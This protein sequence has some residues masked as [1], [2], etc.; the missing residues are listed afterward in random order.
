MKLRKSSHK[1]WPLLL[2]DAFKFK[3]CDQFSRKV[4]FRRNCFNAKLEK[5]KKLFAQQTFL[6]AVDTQSLRF[7]FVLIFTQSFTKWFQ[8]AA[9]SPFWKCLKNSRQSW[10]RFSTARFKKS[11][12]Q[13]RKFVFLRLENAFS[14]NG[15][16][17]YLVAEKR[18]AYAPLS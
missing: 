17:P 15:L 14:N 18:A 4:L 6:S 1:L 16:R 2:L 8:K 5:N 13:L 7:V 10:A 9:K 3:V 11:D 12:W